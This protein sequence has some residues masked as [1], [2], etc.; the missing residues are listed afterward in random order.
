MKLEFILR[1]DTNE[2]TQSMLK[3]MCNMPYQNSFTS[4]IGSILNLNQYDYETLIIKAEETVKIL[5]SEKK[6]K[7]KTFNENVIKIRKV[8]D[9]KNRYEYSDK[10]F[11]LLKFEVASYVAKPFRRRR[12]GVTIKIKLKLDI[13]LVLLFCFFL[14]ILLQISKLISVFLTRYTPDRS[15]PLDYNS[16]RTNGME[17]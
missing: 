16:V 9:S 17:Q 4:E 5:D 14:I 7:I 2:L 6:S 11:N 12:L 10:L 13:N 15:H 3:I 8:L 1:L